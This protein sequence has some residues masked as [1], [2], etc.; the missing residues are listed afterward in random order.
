MLQEVEREHGSIKESIWELRDKEVAHSINMSQ[1]LHP[2][3]GS[4][5]TT[6]IGW[7]VTIGVIIY[8]KRFKLR[9]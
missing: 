1:G 4:C 6:W 5:A 7:E 8:D 9:Q 2:R 3:I